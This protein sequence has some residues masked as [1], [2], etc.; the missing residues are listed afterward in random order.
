M[1]REHRIGVVVPAYNEE[2]LIRETLTGIPEYVDKIYAVDD[3]SKDATAKV[4]QAVQ[5]TDKRIVFIQHEKNKGVGGAIVSG[6][7]KALEEEMD[8]AAVMAGDNQMDPVLLPQFLDPIVDGRADYT[9]GNRLLSHEYRRGMTKWRFIGNSLLTFLTKV[10]SG[11]WQLMDPQN[12][13]T[14]ISKTALERLSLDSVYPWYGYCN[15]LLVRLNVQGF[16]VKDVVMPAKYG[17]EKSGIKYSKYIVKVSWLL[18]KDFFW[19]LQMKY[20]ILSFHP[21]VLFYFFGIILAPLGFLGILYSLY[22]KFVEGGPL[23]IRATLSLLA[24]ML[25][26]QFLLFAMLFDMQVDTS[27]RRNSRWE[28]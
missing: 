10:G 28:E 13:Y 5:E 12:G 6:Y 2:K 22:Y 4:I 16:R 14:A 17:R 1:Y 25:G 18:L 11:Y 20:V 3:A 15:D 19:R 27:E 21:L 24:F 23:F 9:K 7:K 8:I 26:V